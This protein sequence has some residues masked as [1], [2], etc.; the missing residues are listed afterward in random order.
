MPGFPE[1]VKYDAVGLAELVRLKEIQP[2]EIIEAAID[3]IERHNSALNAVIF[4]RYESARTE[5][6]QTRH[7]PL[8]GAPFLMKN[9]GANVAGLPY[10]A[11]SSVLKNNVPDHDTEHTARLKGA[12]LI[13]LG[14]T[15]VPEL[16]FDA[17]TEPDLYGPTRNPWNLERTAGGS[18]GGSAAAVAAGM[19]PMAHATDGG[20]SIRAPAAVCGLFGLKPTRLRNPW[21][22]DAGD[23][24]F[25][26]AVQHVVSRSV[27]DSAAALDATAGTEPGAP[28]AA[29]NKE[30]PFLQEV[31]ANPGRLRIAFTREAQSE[32]SVHAE[33]VRAVEEA[34]V[35]CAD[36][37]HQVDE[38]APP[39]DQKDRDV[40]ARLF[41][42]LVSG[43]HAALVD[44]FGQIIGRE[45]QVDEFEISTRA[46]IDYGRRL[47]A[48]DLIHALDTTHRLG[49]EA[50][51]FMRNYD[52]LLTPT[53][54][55]PPIPLGVLAPHNPDLDAH[56]AN[57]FS[58]SAFTPMANVTGQP[59]MS[60]PLHQS[61]DNLPIG[62]HFTARFGDEATLFRIAAQL[63]EARP[64]A[65][66]RPPIFG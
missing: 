24:L 1:Y 51:Q 63:E 33:C 34:A 21:G 7:G 12:G 18:S 16:G 14:S 46:S 55:S 57:V 40:A 66:R 22:P 42:L 62:V 31:G 52:L 39:F 6:L 45:I 58:F 49:R 50:A 11:G 26:L 25:G 17:S 8:A 10:T 32:A 19:V 43:L 65:K 5:A 23:V 47:T 9:L 61:A 28:Y 2:G 44:D 35:L 15:N 48:V 13:I 60:I 53:M 37:G 56:M 64:W 30:R 36:L 59:A 38:A 54:A 27:R 41:T 20:G 3:I 4:R 29:P